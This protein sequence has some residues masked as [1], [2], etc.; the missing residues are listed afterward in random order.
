MASGQHVPYGEGVD[1]TIELLERSPVAT[2]VLTPD[3]LVRFVNT[4]FERIFGYAREEIVGRAYEELFPER[5]QET[6]RGRLDAFFAAPEQ[7]IAFRPDFTARRKDGTEFPLQYVATPIES[8]L[9]LWVVVTLFDRTAER[10]AA[11]RIESLNRSY[12]TLARMNQAVGRASSVAELFEETC[13][14]AVEEGG[15][16]GAWVGEIGVDDVVQTLATCG[17]IDDYVSALRI[18][19]DAADPTSAGPTG[20]ALRESHVVYVDDFATDPRTSPWREEAGPYGIASS[21]SLPLRRGGRAVAVLNLYGDKPRVFDQAARDLLEGLADNV[22]FALDGFERA[23]RLAEVSAQRQRLLRR[24]VTAEEVERHRLAADIHDDSVQALAAAEL[25]LSSIEA[26]ARTAAP[27]LAPRIVAVREALATAMGSLRGLMFDLE[28]AGADD[29]L[30]VALREVAGQVFVD[31]RVHWE[32]RVAERPME[33]VRRVQALRIAKEALINVRKHADA[34]VVEV[35][36][37]RDGVGMQF[38]VRDNG[39]GLGEEHGA[40]PGHRGLQTMR[41][42]AELSGGWFRSGPAP[43]GGTEVAWWLPADDVEAEDPGPE[44]PGPASSRSPRGGP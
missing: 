26:A 25:R 41:E 20:R 36:A 12:L 7:P 18:R 8:R 42:R 33:R 13:R 1:L 30:V 22:S 24:L 38:R 34:T 17:Q 10:E 37:Q 40:R 2:L 32:V 6:L 16:L 39:G 5:L 11:E 29:T 44:Q 31:S 28:P 23:R 35:E 19:L 3:H 4:E 21:V 27:D 14:V 15:F 43:G 9:G